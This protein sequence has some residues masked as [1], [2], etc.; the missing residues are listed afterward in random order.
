MS[1]RIRAAGIVSTAA[2]LVLI[3]VGAALAAEQDQGSHGVVVSVVIK[4]LQACVGACTDAGGD[5]P[6]T[7]GA[8]PAFFIWTAAA[9]LTAGLAFALWHRLRPADV[10]GWQL[11]MRS[12]ASAVV[13]GARGASTDDGLALRGDRSEA[14]EA[15]PDHDGEQGDPQCRRT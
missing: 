8:F 2:V 3:P 12:A 7:G 4:P 9:L 13:P 1:P 15:G 10:T 6:A 14:S 5:L 11:W